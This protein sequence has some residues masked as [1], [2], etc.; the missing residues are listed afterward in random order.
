[1]AKQDGVFSKKMRQ[2]RRMRTDER[3]FKHLS[4]LFQL[5]ARDED[6]LIAIADHHKLVRISEVFVRPQLWA[7]TPALKDLDE[8]EMADLHRRVFGEQPGPATTAATTSESSDAPPATTDA[9]EAAGA[10]A[11]ATSTTDDAAPPELAT[12]DAPLPVAAATTNPTTPAPAEPVANAPQTT[13]SK[14]KT[15][16]SKLK[17]TLGKLRP[18]SGKQSTEQSTEQ[19]PAKSAGSS[20]AQGQPATTTHSIPWLTEQD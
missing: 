6:V 20:P 9:T 8:A 1:M 11:T 3:L 15:S 14:L 7:Q 18:V 17:A 10:A 13:V 2:W 5:E 4:E 12:S 16:A 19:G